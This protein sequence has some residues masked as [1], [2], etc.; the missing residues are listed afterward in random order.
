MGLY[1]GSSAKLKINSSKN[2]ILRLNIPVIP[3]SPI[4]N[5]VMLKSLD[6]YILKDLN[7][8][9]LTVKEDK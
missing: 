8:I 3:S 6:N 7:G 9:Y 1:L 5:G 2:G 4:V